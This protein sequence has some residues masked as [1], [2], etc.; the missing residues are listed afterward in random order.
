MLQYKQVAPAGNRVL[1][2]VEASEEKSFGGILLPSAAQKKPTEGQIVNAG[3]AL[4]V[5]VSCVGNQR[6]LVL[7][8]MRQAAAWKGAGPVCI[9][10]TLPGVNHAMRFLMQLLGSGTRQSRS[11]ELIGHWIRFHAIS[12]ASVLYMNRRTVC[13]LALPVPLSGHREMPRHNENVSSHAWTHCFAHCTR[14]AV[15]VHLEILV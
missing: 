11:P 9:P 10:K 12:S 5:K 7:Q 3:T 8:L 2:K 4:A 15:E 13:A 6:D 14:S 1:V